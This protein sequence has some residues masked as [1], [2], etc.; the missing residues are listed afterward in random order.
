[1]RVVPRDIQLPSLLG[2]EFLFLEIAVGDLTPRPPSLRGKGGE[3]TYTCGC[4]NDC[5]LAGSHFGSR[6]LDI[7]APSLG[8]IIKF[9]RT[10]L[11]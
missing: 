4:R 10:L 6:I 5:Q 8:M 3:K 1:M 7:M 2:R 11:Q 9:K